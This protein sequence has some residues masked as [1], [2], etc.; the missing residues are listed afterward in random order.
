M[1]TLAF[2][3]SLILSASAQYVPRF[4]TA[5]TKDVGTT[6]NKVVQLDGDAK[7]PAVDGSALTGIS[8]GGGSTPG[9][10]VWT[11]TAGA[12]ASAKLTTDNSNPVDTTAIALN[13]TPKNGG[14]VTAVLDKLGSGTVIVLTASTGKSQFFRHT[15]A[16]VNAGGVTS[17]TV[18]WIGGDTTAW[19]G[20]YQV[21]F[22][23]STDFLTYVATVNGASGAITIVPPDTGWTAPESGGDKAATLPNYSTPN[24]DGVDLVDKTALTALAT[25]VEKLTLKL[26]ALQTALTANL[27]PGP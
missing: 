3:L 14:S 26:Q 18:A 27:R 25:Q 16:P 1:K 9:L 11:Y 24:L 8:G 10:P 4:G 15:A 13:D 20:D 19:S 12:Q 5:A 21:S 6:A 2:F 17:Y 22:G 23:F 7:L